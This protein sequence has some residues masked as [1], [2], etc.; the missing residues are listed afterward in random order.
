MSQTFANL[1]LLHELILAESEYTAAADAAL[2]HGLQAKNPMTAECQAELCRLGEDM[3]RK[4][5]Q[6]AAAQ[7]A[8]RKREAE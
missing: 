4:D 5:M 8:F 6:R 3:W 1:S 2:A 7:E